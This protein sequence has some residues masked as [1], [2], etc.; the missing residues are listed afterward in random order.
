MPYGH[1]KIFIDVESQQG[2]GAKCQCFVGMAKGARRIGSTVFVVCGGIK[3]KGTDIAR[4]ICKTKA[5]G[6]W[7]P[8]GQNKHVTRL[9]MRKDQRPKITFVC[10]KRAIGTSACLKCI[11]LSSST[12]SISDHVFVYVDCGSHCQS[13]EFNRSRW[14]GVC[15]NVMVV[16]LLAGHCGTCSSVLWFRKGMGSSERSRRRSSVDCGIQR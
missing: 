7:E 14:P 9:P 3:V 15:C 10:T 16:Y 12:S 1:D 13:A 2:L 8:R 11:T 6:V 5:R 4:N